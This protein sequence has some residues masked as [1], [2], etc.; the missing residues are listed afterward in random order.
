MTTS[1][2]RRPQAGSRLWHLGYGASV[3]SSQLLQQSI[4]HEYSAN[5]T[6][7]KFNVRVVSNTAVNYTSQK[8]WYLVLK[9]PALSKGWGASRVRDALSQ[10]AADLPP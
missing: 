7:I 9:S 8:G 10:Q 1:C 6:T 4:T 5:G 3:L 2:C